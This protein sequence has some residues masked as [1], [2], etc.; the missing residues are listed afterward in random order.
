MEHDQSIG[1]WIKQRRKALDLTQHDLARLVGCAV[2]TIQKIEEGRRR[3]SRQIAALLAEHLELADQERAEF[4]RFARTTESVRTPTRVEPAPEPAP[5]NLPSP[6]TALIGRS[7]DVATV[8]TA[9]DRPEVRLL[10][11]VGPPGVG[12][13]RLSIQVASE[14]CDQFNDG[15]WFVALAPIHDGDLVMPT[16]A[17]ALGFTEVGAQPLLERLKA[18]LRTKRILLVLD[19][20]EQLVDVAPP[21]S[22]LL[23]ACPQLKVLATSRIP[24]RLY[25]EHLYTVEPLALPDE[26]ST[27]TVEGLM[28]SDAIRL[29]VARVQAFKPDFSLT[30]HNAQPITDIC[31]RLDGLPL[32][33]E[34]AAARIARFTPEALAARLSSAGGDPFP[35]LSGG[36]RDLPARQQTLH[37]AIAWSYN[38]LDAARQQLFR[39]LGVFVG[40]CTAAAA[41]AVCGLASEE[42]LAVLVEQS[43]VRRDMHADAPTRFVMLEMLREYAL[44]QLIEHDEQAIFERAHAAYFLQRAEDSEDEASWLDRMEADYDNV[45]AALQWSAAHEAA[46][47]GLRLVTALWWFWESHGYWN[48]GRYWIGSMLATASDASPQLRME[49]LKCAGDLAWKQGD[50]AQ[51]SARLEESLALSRATREQRFTDNVLMLLGKIALDQGNYEVATARLRESLVM[52]RRLK[53]PQPGMLM[54]LGE[55]AL[56]QGNYTEAHKLFEESLAESQESADLFFMVISTRMLGETALE[57]GDYERARTLIE[58]S[59]RLSRD[60]QHRRVRVFTLMAFAA[61]LGYT[62]ERS[63][64]QLQR[65]ARIW[66]AAEVLR[67]E[68]GIFLPL[69]N[70]IRYERDLANARSH[71]TPAEW[72][73]AWAEGRAMSLRQAVAYALGSLSSPS[74]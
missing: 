31:I 52:S 49:A 14:L 47:T 68:V 74:A 73:T 27:H 22:D 8:C 1:R 59:L 71:L 28:E 7:V 16:I 56:A 67:E 46:E 20:V 37:S 63:S 11:L 10:T 60:I 21:I 66:G 58:Q 9:L 48:E 15:V 23:T 26:A 40:G 38:L 13:T 5:T 6:L 34:L 53:I 33:L 42:D 4:L 72:A 55:V 32:A 2:V 44:A 25:G 65:A 36:P 30:S 62:P 43:L 3:P 54:H 57:E 45:R 64:D 18:A 70:R 35:L 29:F 51:A 24:L 12:K 61:A 41:M 19:N 17:R 39:R 50:F 69:D